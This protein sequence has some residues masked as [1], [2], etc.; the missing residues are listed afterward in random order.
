MEGGSITL[1]PTA[2]TVGSDASATLSDP[3]GEIADITWTWETSANQI[4]WNRATGAVSSTGVNSMYTPVNADG[5]NYLRA[6]V[7]Y[8]DGYGTGN[9]VISA[10]VM[11]TARDSNPVLIK[12]D[13]NTDGQIDRNEALV[14]LRK[15]RNNEA[16]R[17]E[18]LEVL[19]L[20][21]LYRESL[22]Q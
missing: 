2:L 6:V 10:S 13:T 3:D 9:R 8:R 16:S 14:A 7:A 5:G 22:S 1:S 15:Y 17:D 20:Y 19:R 21:R 4:T 18:V 11:V 12:Y